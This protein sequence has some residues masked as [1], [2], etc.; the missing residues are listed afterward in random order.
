MEPSVCWNL[1]PFAAVCWNRIVSGACFLAGGVLNGNLSHRRYVAMLCML[2]KI[3][4]NPMHPLCGVLPVP[5]VPVRVTRG[6]LI[7]HRYTYAPPRCRT[8]QYPKLL[9]SSQYLSGPIW[10]TPYSMVWDW[11]VSRAGP[12]PF[13]FPSCSLLFCLQLFSLSLLFQY[14]LVVWGLGLRTDRVSISLSLP[15]IANI[16]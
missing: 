10:L 14:R 15:C 12:M 5:Y 8:S 4:C 7:S 1:Q 16:F 11:R 9:F 3:R 13:C 2:Y 6:T